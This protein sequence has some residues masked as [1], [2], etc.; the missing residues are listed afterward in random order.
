MDEL[1][2]VC[3][4]PLLLLRYKRGKWFLVPLLYGDSVQLGAHVDGGMSGTGAEGRSKV[5]K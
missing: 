3:A 1:G 5:S 2:S 4:N